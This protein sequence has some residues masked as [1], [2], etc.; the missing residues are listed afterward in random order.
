MQLNKERYNRQLLLAGFGE[1]AQLKL[2]Q[3]RVLVVG[4]GGLGVPVLQ[5]LSG[6]GVGKIGIIDH[7]VVAESNLHRQVLYT[8]NDIGEP[9]ANKAAERLNALNPEVEYIVFNELLTTGNALSVIGLFDVVVDCTDNFP[10]RYLINDACVILNKPFVYG[11]IHQYEGQVSVF[12]HNGSATYRCLFPT[13]PEVGVV[14]DCN[15]NG[16]LGILPGIIGCYQANETIKLLTGIGELL[17]NK[18]L[19]IDTLFNQQRTIRFQPKS[20]LPQITRLDSDDYKSLCGSA[21]LRNMSVSELA[22][23]IKNNEAIQLVDVREDDEL[24]IC[25]IA[26]SI[27]I[28]LGEIVAKANKIDGSQPV[29]MICHHGIRSRIA[30]EEL[31]K[32]GFTNIFNLTGGIH[33]WALEIDKTM[34]VY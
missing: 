3:S 25:Q 24:A 20:D 4:A 29:I 23:R 33:A 26:D 27:H 9:K 7:D 11:A 22:S 32:K 13:A 18:M 16:V 28:P 30:G 5:Y 2:L 21:R 19:I 17:A 1:E 10:T 12:N 8:T 14:Q 34:Q 31:L 6:M 15:T